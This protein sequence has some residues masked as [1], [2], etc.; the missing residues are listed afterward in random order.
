MNTPSQT[1]DKLR[2]IV[3]RNF[4]T[5]EN[6]KVTTHV[7][8]IQ[9]AMREWAAVENKEL[10]EK[11]ETWKR[12][13]MDSAGACNRNAARLEKVQEELEALKEKYEL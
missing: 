7:E 11:V 4:T 6:G 13:H 10:R 8:I 1:P 9:D 3:E 5:E 12:A 2:E